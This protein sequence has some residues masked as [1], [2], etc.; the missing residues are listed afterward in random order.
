MPLFQHTHTHTHTHT[1]KTKKQKK[2]EKEEWQPPDYDDNIQNDDNENFL[3]SKFLY[4]NTILKGSK[5]E[6]VPKKLGPQDIGSNETYEMPNYNIDNNDN[7]SFLNQ[8][9]SS[10]GRIYLSLS[11]FI[12]IF[13]FFFVF[14]FLLFFLQVSNKNIKKK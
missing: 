9:I 13:C 11:L 10:I 8:K 4:P 12:T 7:S 1:H 2:W 14:C 6:S 5:S 3:K